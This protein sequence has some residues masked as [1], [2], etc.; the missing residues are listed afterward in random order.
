MVMIG[1]PNFNP[2]ISENGLGLVS[3]STP[4]RPAVQPHLCRSPLADPSQGSAEGSDVVCSPH[5][6][7]LRNV[8][9]VGQQLACS[10]AW[11][12]KTPAFA[13]ASWC[14]RFTTTFPNF[15][16]TLFPSLFS[17]GCPLFDEV[18]SKTAPGNPKCRRKRPPC[19]LATPSW[20]VSTFRATPEPAQGASHR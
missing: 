17:F 18:S 10:S 15:F 20:P 2:S 3:V 7:N 4:A 13:S 5:G 12:P 6:H 16:D 14:I 8:G 9:C 1:I 19:R 11:Q